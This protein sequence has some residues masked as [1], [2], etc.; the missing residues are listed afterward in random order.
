[1][2]LKASGWAV[3]SCFDA[4]FD[5]SEQTTSNFRIRTSINGYYGDIGPRHH[6]DSHDVRIVPVSDC[7]YKVVGTLVNNH[8]FALEGTGVAAVN[9]FDAHGTIVGCTEVS[10]DA[11]QPGESQVFETYWLHEKQGHPATGVL[12]QAFA[13]PLDE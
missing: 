7:C 2:S 11:L 13:W 1:M 3:S 10:T 5:E 12:V 9:V 8:S 4:Y 6:L